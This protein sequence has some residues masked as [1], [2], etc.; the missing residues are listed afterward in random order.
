MNRNM[1]HLIV[2]TWIPIL[3]RKVKKKTNSN[4]APLMGPIDLLTIYR[5]E[6]LYDCADAPQ[7]RAEHRRR[8]FLSFQSSLSYLRKFFSKTE[9]FFLSFRHTIYY[10]QQKMAFNWNRMCIHKFFYTFLFK[11][12][13]FEF[14]RALTYQTTTW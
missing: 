7:Q 6:Y 14:F 10:K 4:P 11:K 8:H 5:V 2:G 1:Y 12:T 13:C 9:K 3:R